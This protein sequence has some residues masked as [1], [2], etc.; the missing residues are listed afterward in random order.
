MSHK[1]FDQQDLRTLAG[2]I[3]EKIKKKITDLKPESINPIRSITRVDAWNEKVED[4]RT[5][6]EKPQKESSSRR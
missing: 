4:E 5:K 2:R 6:D 3:N 1:D